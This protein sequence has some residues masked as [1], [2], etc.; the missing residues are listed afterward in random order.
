MQGKRKG[1]VQQPLIKLPEGDAL[2]GLNPVANQSVRN[3]RL[4]DG[5]LHIILNKKWSG[6]DFTSDDSGRGE[7]HTAS[8][9]D[10]VHFR[11]PKTC[12]DDKACLCL[13]KDIT[14]STEPLEESYK[15]SLSVDGNKLSHPY[16]HPLW[17]EAFLYTRQREAKLQC[18]HALCKEAGN[19]TFYTPLTASDYKQRPPAVNKPHFGLLSKDNELKDLPFLLYENGFIIAPL[20]DS[21]R[22]F[23]F[24]YHNY[25][26]E[27]FP[28]VVSKV[29]NGQIAVCLTPDCLS[30]IE[31]NILTPQEFQ[32]YL[33]DLEEF[34]DRYRQDVVDTMPKDET[35]TTG[36]QRVISRDDSVEEYCE[37]CLDDPPSKDEYRARWVDCKQSCDQVGEEFP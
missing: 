26:P 16:V 35:S 10:G 24:G 37:S 1:A 15:Q 6:N 31:A 5:D 3:G 36:Q 12:D 20:D 14:V 7:S 25:I 13:C 17:K 32:D 21:D 27:Q 8:Y 2:I 30:R 9:Q 18:T 29:E 33:D 19:T 4:G 28:V 22:P 34:G 11:R 23:P